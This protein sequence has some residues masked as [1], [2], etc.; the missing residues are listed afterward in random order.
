MNMAYRLLVLRPIELL[1]E[2]EN[3]WNKNECFVNYSLFTDSMHLELHVR[4]DF[5]AFYRGW[6]PF[7]GTGYENYDID[8]IT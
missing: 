4:Y 3:L 5:N 7:T 2:F 6:T 1:L 8:I